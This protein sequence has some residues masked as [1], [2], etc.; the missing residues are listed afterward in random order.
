MEANMQIYKHLTFSRNDIFLL[1]EPK[2][3]LK[4]LFRLIKVSIEIITLLEHESIFLH[5]NFRV[6]NIKLACFAPYTLRNI[7][8]GLVSKAIH[9]AHQKLFG[10]FIE[11]VNDIFFDFFHF[12]VLF[13]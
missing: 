1:S 11:L 10:D 2:V 9:F 3:P 12:L 13:L 7:S 5:I 6:G 8:I 4:V